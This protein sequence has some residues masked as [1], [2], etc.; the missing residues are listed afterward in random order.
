MGRNLFD[1]IIVGGGPAGLNAAIVLGRSNRR[2]LLFDAGSQRNLAS[3]GMHN[4]LTRDNI[5]PVDF[6]KE[7]RKEAK[8]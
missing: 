4:Y 1:V 5:K 2:V 8:K 3:E 6:I 7:S